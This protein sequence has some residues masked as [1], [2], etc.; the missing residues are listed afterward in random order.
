MLRYD[1]TL[2]PRISEVPGEK[3]GSYSVTANTDGLAPA[4]SVEF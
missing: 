1:S 4:V 2:R 3:D